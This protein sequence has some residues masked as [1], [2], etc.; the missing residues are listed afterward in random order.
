MYSEHFR[1]IKRNRLQDTLS[2]R[3]SREKGLKILQL[4]RM[5]SRQN[6]PQFCFYQCSAFHQFSY[7]RQ[8]IFCDF[9]K[10]ISLVL[11]TSVTVKSLHNSLLLFAGLYK[12]V[13]RELC[14][15]SADVK[16]VVK[17]IKIKLN[18]PSNY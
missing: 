17:K 14:Y 16:N 3:K 13:H 7:T 12:T 11:N 15:Y 10:F 8:R 9:F 5:F 4:T 1:Q 6:F 2:G 18:N